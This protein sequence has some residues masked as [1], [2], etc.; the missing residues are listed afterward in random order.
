M[1]TQQF[2]KFQIANRVFKELFRIINNIL[3]LQN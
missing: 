1:S 2:Q 3:L